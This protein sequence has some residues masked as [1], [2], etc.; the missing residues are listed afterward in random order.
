MGLWD[1]LY[2]YDNDSI[3]YEVPIDMKGKKIKGVGNGTSNSDAVNYQ[4]LIDHIKTINSYYF[5][6]N[7][8]EH[9]NENKVKFPAISHHPYSAIKN[10]E[11]LRISLKG[12]Y[13]IIYTDA[14]KRKCKFMIADAKNDNYLFVQYFDDVT[15]WTPLIV[16]A[17]IKVDINP[18]TNYLDIKMNIK[19]PDRLLNPILDGRNNSTFF[20]KYLN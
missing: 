6:T 4:Q 18:P 17:V 16:S 11:N 1:R 14:Y 19:D 8:L 7:Y 13:Q 9:D 20:I 2:Y 3:E 12:F 15:N 10:S 5:Y